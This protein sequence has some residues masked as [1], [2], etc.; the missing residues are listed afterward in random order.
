MSNIM[1]SVESGFRIG[2]ALGGGIRRRREEDEY[3]KAQMLAEQSWQDAHVAEMTMGFLNDG[4][5]ADVAGD[6]GKL[7]AAEAHG[8]GWGAGGENFQFDPEKRTLSFT[9]PGDDGKP[10]DVTLGERELKLIVEK[11]RA[12]V[13]RFQEFRQKAGQGRRSGSGRALGGGGES[14]NEEESE[15]KKAKDAKSVE[16]EVFN[17]RAAAADWVEKADRTPQ[18]FAEEVSG[19]ETELKS[20][21]SGRGFMLPSTRREKISEL[22]DQ[23]E[24]YDTLA[25]E[26]K[27]PMRS[28]TRK[29]EAKR[30]KA[31]RDTEEKDRARKW[32]EENPD[33]PRAKK[34]LEMLK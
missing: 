10:M 8:T 28:R 14:E 20:L 23:I 26:G 12:N 32:A 5:P 4:V 30:A 16:G 33:D 18:A 24:H 7:Y 11:N 25:A 21:E 29:S 9:R 6:F 19:W 1:A 13:E 22:Q 31:P 15:L 3:K 17:L 2:S 27:L 34:I